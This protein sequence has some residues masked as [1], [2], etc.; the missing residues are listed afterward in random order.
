MVKAKLYIEGYIGEN[1]GF[2]E[3]MGIDSNTFSAKDLSTFLNNNQ[4]AE[5]I[6]VE[7]RSG[8]GSVEQGIDI[9]DQLMNCGKTVTTIAYECASIATVIFLAGSKRLVSK[10]AMPLIHNPYIDGF[11]VSG[12]DADALAELSDAVRAQEN[13][14]LDIY[15]ERA[16][17]DRTILSD[18]MSMD[19]QIS[20]DK[21]MELGFAT[22]MIN[23]NPVAARKVFAY[24][25]AH[26]NLNNQ[27]MKTKEVKSLF[28]KMMNMLNEALSGS[29]VNLELMLEDGNTVWVKTEATEAKVGDEVYTDAEFTMPVEDGTHTLED[30]A[31]IVTEK[32]ADGIALITEI[33]AASTDAK[34]DEEVADLKAKIATL[35]T[36][37]STLEIEKNGLQAKL[38]S[39][40]QAKASHDKSLKAIKAEFDDFKA[41]V[42]DSADD[43]GAANLEKSN[44]HKALELRK[45][46][47][48]LLKK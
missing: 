5:E 46:Q 41:L 4:D 20:A 33:L 28:S 16:G 12:L 30:G 34:K 27:Y 40:V 38:D 18:I 48:N 26:S 3:A 9:Y 19:K 32:N 21:F 43:A 15:V 1:D 45:S 39:M 2:M 22:E 6:E 31:T 47:R 36:S 44:A 11:A 13:R 7:I 8:G 42:L 10:N 24:I 35:E 37:N 14:I 23:G 29:I 17:A 25:K